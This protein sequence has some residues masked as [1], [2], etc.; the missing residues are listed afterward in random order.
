MLRNTRS[1]NGIEKIKGKPKSNFEM[2]GK[3]KGSLRT[4]RMQKY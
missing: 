1:R 4:G 3:F 2:N